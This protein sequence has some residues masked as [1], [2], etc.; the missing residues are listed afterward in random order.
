MSLPLL[1]GERPENQCP[2]LVCATTPHLY[3]RNSWPPRIVAMSTTREQSHDPGTV[4]FP[5]HLRSF[6]K[7]DPQQFKPELVD[8]DL[9]VNLDDPDYVTTSRSAQHCS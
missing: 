9:D 7:N 8:V 1:E 2:C 6:Q 3:R 5:V 4:T